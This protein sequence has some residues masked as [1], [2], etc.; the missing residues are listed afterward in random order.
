LNLILDIEDNMVLKSSIY[1]LSEKDEYRLVQNKEAV[2]M[3]KID[4]PDVIDQVGL[5]ENLLS[6]GEKVKQ[7]SEN[8]AESSKSKTNF[9]DKN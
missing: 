9:L 2:S 5:D 4:S 3:N 8:S 6:G 7:I 1:S